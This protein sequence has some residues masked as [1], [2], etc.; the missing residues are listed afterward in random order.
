M[1]IRWRY[2]QRYKFL[3]AVVAFVTAVT[4]GFSAF[5]F[6]SSLSLWLVIVVGIV[7]LAVKHPVL[8]VS[9]LLLLKSSLDTIAQ[10]FWFFEG[11]PLAS[12][13]NGVLNV[14]VL[15]I[16]ICIGV[17]RYRCLRRLY[18]VRPWLV[19]LSLGLFGILISIDRIDAVREWTR[20]ASPFAI[21]ILIAATLHGRSGVD[22]YVKLT[23]LSAFVPVVVG[24]HQFISGTG[25]LVTPGLNRIHSTFW[26][27]ASYSFYLLVVIMV[28]I[29]KIHLGPVSVTK[30]LRIALAGFCALSL[31]FTYT[32]SAWLG[33]LFAVCIFG[34]FYNRRLLFAVVIIVFLVVLTVPSVKERFKEVITAETFS[35]QPT[36]QTP[37]TALGASNSLQWRIIFWKE[38]LSLVPA[39]LWTGYGVGSFD[40]LAATTRIGI[41]IAAHNDYLRILVEMGIPGLFVFLWLQLSTLKEAWEV[42]RQ[43]KRNWQ[44]VFAVAFIGLYLSMLLIAS[45]DNVL[46][47]H[48]VGWYL[49][50]FAAIVHRLRS[51]GC[52]NG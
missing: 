17:T 11:T 8:A 6:P 51:E 38:M 40:G 41:S 37:Q 43:H 15:L 24:L 13:L 3:L 49:W 14:L 34:V 39:R 31:L 50:A 22:R 4:I 36:K 44:S 33:V 21:Y 27:P 1:K 9:T 25:S 42:Y 26:Y 47:F 2:Q 18:T 16:A 5:F 29:P 23:T 30:V 28:L 52:S 48:T 32:R 12:N 20:L 46:S 35:L 19:F 45:V 7:Y 10:R